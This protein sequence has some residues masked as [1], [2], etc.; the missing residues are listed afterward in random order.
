MGMLKYVLLVALAACTGGASSTGIAQVSCPTDS[1]L[2]YANFGQDFMATNCLS[3]HATKERPFLSTQAEV[4]ANASKILQEAVYTDAMPQDSN[5]D[6]A[7]REM[8]GEW[9]ACGAP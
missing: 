4:K 2:S 6:N 3:C 7:E 5:M 1:T 9:L 8:L